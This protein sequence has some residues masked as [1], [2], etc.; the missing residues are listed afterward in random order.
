MKSQLPVSLS[1]LLP[2]EKHLVEVM[3]KL[4]FGHISRL[5][6][7]GGQPVFT[8]PCVIIRQRK[9]DQEMLTE[10]Q[11][12][13]ADYVLKKSIVQLV[14]HIRSVERGEIIRLAF[15][16]GQPDLMEEE[17]ALFESRS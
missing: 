7:V 11:P 14:L 1:D 2:P 13:D 15:R 16:H 3:R 5:A 17:E 9:F 10:G 12:A 6:I 4:R 8:P